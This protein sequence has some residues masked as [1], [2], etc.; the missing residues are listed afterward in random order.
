MAGVTGS[1]GGRARV[2]IAGLSDGEE[3][4]RE[5][6]EWTR[7]RRGGWLDRTERGVRSRFSSSPFFDETTS[8]GARR[9]PDDRRRFSENP[10]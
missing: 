2:T 5:L 3:L 9:W 10:L 8:W 7:K 4:A 6:R 1:V